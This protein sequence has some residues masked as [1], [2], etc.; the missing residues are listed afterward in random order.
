LPAG[1][2]PDRFNCWQ[3]DYPRDVGRRGEALL[4]EVGVDAVAQADGD[5]RQRAGTITPSP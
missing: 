1:Q 2:Q 4:V 3:A 5:Q